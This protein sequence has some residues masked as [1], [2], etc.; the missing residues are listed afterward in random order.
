LHVSSIGLGT[1]LGDEDDPHDQAYTDAIVAAVRAGCNV[2]DTA[3]NYRAQ[4]S[5]R[6]VGAA[7]ARLARAYGIAREEVVVCTK[8]GYLPFDGY[9]PADSAAYFRDVYV[10]TGVLAEDDIVAGSHAMTPR[11]LAD[12]L[13]RSLRNL[14]VAHVDVYYLHNPETQLLHLDR[15]AFLRRLR[16]AFAFLEE[17]VRDGRVGRYGVA[18]WHGFRRSPTARDH[19][20][21]TELVREAQAIAGDAHHF[22]VI[23]LP[24]NLAMPEAYATP[25]QQVGA[26]LVSPI[27]AAERLGIAVVTSAALLQGQLAH[28]LPRVLAEAFPGLDTAAQRALQ[29]ARSTP[30]VTTALAGMGHATHVAENLRVAA[31]EPATAG[32]DS[33]IERR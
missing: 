15:P 28:R 31:T 26:D 30:G 33:L 1:Y 4:R 12:Q 27:V 6:A 9:V 21:L 22:A 17:A 16:A 23:Q 18:T 10:R 32:V 7:L 29:F 14:G 5:E 8:G 20:G 19:L 3:V 25:T 24:Y 2:L 11:Y 13:D